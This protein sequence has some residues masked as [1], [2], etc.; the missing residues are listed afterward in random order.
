MV[1]IDMNM[2]ACFLWHTP[3]ALCL[4]PYHVPND[5]SAYCCKGISLI[6]SGSIV[7]IWMP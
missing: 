2:K 7:N 4:L 3:P 6:I 5:L 1:Y